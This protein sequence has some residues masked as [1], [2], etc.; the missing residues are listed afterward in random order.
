MLDKLMKIV[1]PNLAGR[2]S[3]SSPSTCQQKSR[4][5]EKH[6]KGYQNP[7]QIHPKSRKSAPGRGFRNHLIGR[8]L[9]KFTK[10]T[11]QMEP[12]CCP[13]PPQKGGN[14]MS[15]SGSL[16]G[17]SPGVILGT[18][19]NDF[20]VILVAFWAHAHT[21]THTHKHTRTHTSTHTRAHTHKRPHTQHTHPAHTQTQSQTHTQHTQHT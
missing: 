13:G 15:N 6:E 8:F 16:F 5:S 20:E 9:K 18:F 14:S 3:R 1:G 12:K 21:N 7:F 19:L 4:G 11:S 2:H 10:M 17:R